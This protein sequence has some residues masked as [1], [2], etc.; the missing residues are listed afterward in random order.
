MDQPCGN[1]RS[2]AI[3]PLHRVNRA[4]RTWAVQYRP[5][6]QLESTIM[7]PQSLRIPFMLEILTDNGLRS[8]GDQEWAS[9]HLVIFTKSWGVQ[10]ISQGARPCFVCL[11][12]FPPI[13]SSSSLSEQSHTAYALIALLGMKRFYFYCVS[14]SSSIKLYLIRSSGSL[15]LISYKS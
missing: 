1:H 6:W 12:I 9:W 13:S 7:R 2:L 3:Y 14:K 8:V 4:W 5:Q 11:G 10:A 15:I